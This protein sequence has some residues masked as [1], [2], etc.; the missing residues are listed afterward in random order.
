MGGDICEEYEIC[1]S[2]ARRG[3]LLA[4]SLT[5]QIV[6]QVHLRSRDLTMTVQKI[7]VT[8]KLV[9]IANKPMHEPHNPLCPNISINILHAVL[10]SPPPG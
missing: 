1:C 9:A 3:N 10:Y 8:L 7:C 4:Q 5:R 6:T 2:E